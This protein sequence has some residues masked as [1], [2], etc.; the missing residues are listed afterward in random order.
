MT[1]KPQTIE[2]TIEELAAIL[3][4]NAV[5]ADKDLSLAE[6]LAKW[7]AAHPDY[8]RLWER[9]ALRFWREKNP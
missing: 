7:R 9:I 8:R 3:R 5:D 2:L 4:V 6:C 1:T